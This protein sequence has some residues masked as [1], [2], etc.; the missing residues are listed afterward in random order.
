MRI[1]KQLKKK[2][3]SVNILTVSLHG[4]AG[5]FLPYFNHG[6]SHG[7]D[8]KLTRSDTVSIEIT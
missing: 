4:N 2:N 7:V 6:G 8:T 5:F 3:S 1:K